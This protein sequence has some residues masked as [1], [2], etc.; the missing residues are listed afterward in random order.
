MEPCYR[1]RYNEQHLKA[2]QNYSRIYGKKTRYNEPHYNE[3]ILTVPTHNLPRYNKYFVL[4]LSV[5]KNNMMI[6][7]A[8]KLNTTCIGQDRETLTSKAL[9]I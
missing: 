6:Q 2:Q 4:S 1:S 7:M 9:L 3:L 8:D 5:S